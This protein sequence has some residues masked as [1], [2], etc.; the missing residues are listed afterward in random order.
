MCQDSAAA[1]TA[2]LR[3]AGA[4]EPALAARRYAR[5]TLAGWHLPAEVT[6]DALL[7]TAELVANAEQHAASAG[8]PQEISFTYRCRHLEIAVSDNEPSGPVAREA[9]ETDESGRGLSIIEALTHAF[10]WCSA[11]RRKTVWAELAA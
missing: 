11:G 3:L 9:E 8:G 2:R 6:D 5:D 1:Q 10:G 7:I 4:D